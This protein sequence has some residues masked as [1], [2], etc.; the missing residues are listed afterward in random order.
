MLLQ[1]QWGLK[2]E[3]LAASE[4]WILNVSCWDGSLWTVGW[5]PWLSLVIP[6]PGLGRWQPLSIS[7][8]C[9]FADL[10]QAERDGS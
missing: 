1:G 9:Y 6:Q 8:G 2:E 10:L 7:C 3:R 5:L 4:M